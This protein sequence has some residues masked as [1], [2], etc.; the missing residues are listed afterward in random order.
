MSNTQPTGKNISIKKKITLPYRGDI[1]RSP[2]V[3][4]VKTIK[5][6]HYPIISP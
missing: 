3:Q 5:G 4:I 1:Y 6:P 2:D